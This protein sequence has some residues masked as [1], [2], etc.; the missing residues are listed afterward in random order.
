[1]TSIEEACPVDAVIG[2]PAGTVRSLTRAHFGR[3]FPRH[4]LVAAWGGGFPEG[5]AMLRD[6]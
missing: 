4:L 1:M 2:R 6:L 5:H 3:H